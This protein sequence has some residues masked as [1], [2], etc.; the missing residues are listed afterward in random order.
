[1]LVEGSLENA[2]SPPNETQLIRVLI[3]DNTR[4]GSQLLAR[5]LAQASQFEV[6][7]TA[8]SSQEARALTNRDP[9]VAL[10]GATL[11]DGPG[12]GFKLSTHIHASQPRT[13]VVMLLDR[14]EPETVV[15]AFRSGAAG[16]VC[17][18][19]P[20]EILCQCICRVNEGKTWATHEELK[21]VLDAIVA[22]APSHPARKL[23][24]LTQREQNVVRFAGEGLSNS[25]I[26]RELRLSK[27]TV[28]NCMAIIFQKLEVSSRTEMVLAVL[29]QALP[30]QS[31]GVLPEDVPELSVDK[32]AV[33]KWYQKAAD[34]ELV[35]AQLTLAQ[36][37][38]EGRGT[39]KDFVTAYMWFLVSENTGSNNL[40]TS[41]RKRDWLRS[42]MTREELAEAEQRAVGWW[43]EHRD[44]PTPALL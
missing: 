28:K 15:E 31:C 6:V 43:R 42:Q 11:A 24:M 44:H 5:A 29:G 19:D 32:R 9:H 35:F 18:D 36:M 8:S 21:F 30:L 26:A 1:M 10:V 38:L 20:V 25:E 7:G 33:F 2:P 41:K 23:H 27:H 34:H 4:M 40:I 17:R 22:S 37:C 12:E 3:V 16:V 13:Q 14:S 39:S